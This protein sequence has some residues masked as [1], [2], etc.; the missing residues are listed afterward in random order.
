MFSPRLDQ[1]ACGHRDEDLNITPDIR[2]QW[3]RS[4]KKH[5]P[6]RSHLQWIRALYALVFCLLLLIFQGW[7]TVVSPFATEDFVA[8]YIAVWFLFKLLQPPLSSNADQPFQIPIFLFLSAAYFFK[9]RGFNP[10]RWYI[11]AERLAGLEAVGPVVVP[12]PSERAACKHCGM[13]HRRGTLAWPRGEG[14]GKQKTMA[15]LE[16]VWAWLK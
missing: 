9:T 1:A 16:W 3:N 11:R 8:G 10:G 6:Y 5:Y 13:R 7:R 2:Y 12:D 4:N 14:L 15:I